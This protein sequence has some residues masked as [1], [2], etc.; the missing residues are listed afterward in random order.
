MDGY[1]KVRPKFCGDGDRWECEVR[2][3]GT[4]YETEVQTLPGTIA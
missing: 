1:A 2:G 3:G 4:F